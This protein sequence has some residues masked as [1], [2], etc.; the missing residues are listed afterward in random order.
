MVDRQVAVVR[1][2]RHQH[3]LR[4]DAERHLAADPV[5]QRGGEWEALGRALHRDATEV[6]SFTGFV[7]GQTKGEKIDYVLVQPGT[8]VLSAGIIRTGENRRYPSD[9]FP[10]VA[11]IQLT[12]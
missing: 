8:T 4:A 12:R 6:G 10:V 7:F 3:A 9:H 2:A 11:R 1:V 5:E